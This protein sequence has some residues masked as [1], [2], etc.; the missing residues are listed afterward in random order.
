MKFA[1]IGAAM[2]LPT[3]GARV[4]SSV[5][6]QMRLSMKQIVEHFDRSYIINLADRTD[7][8]R[9]A[10]REFHNSGI[11]APSKKVQFYTA[12]RP[13]D[14]GG[15]SDVGTRGNFESHRRVLEL[16]KQDGLRNVLVFEDDVCFRDVGDSFK[17]KLMAQLSREEWD[18]V[19]FGYFLPNDDGLTGPLLRWPGD[20]LGAQVYAVNGRFI[21][22][23]IDYMNE[24]E[25]R[26][27]GDPFGCPM[28]AD[29]IYNQVR[30]VFPETALFLSVPNLAHQRASRTD[31]SSTHVL[32]KVSALGPFVRG[33]RTVKNQIRMMRDRRKL[34]RQLDTES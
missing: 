11:S 5:H 23:I 28:G 2:R 6:P 4:I 25:F 8:R 7:R 24:C 22:R 17:H 19:C 16:A 27:H 26:Q 12:T 9:Q 31:I 20:F 21:P 18:V 1:D 14:R 30:R 34:A 32:D 10:E 33:L 15:F 13:V 29:G 3:R